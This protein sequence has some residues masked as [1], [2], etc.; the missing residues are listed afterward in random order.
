MCIHTRLIHNQQNTMPKARSMVRS[1]SFSSVELNV[2]LDQMKSYQAAAAKVAPMKKTYNNNNQPQPPAVAA[3]SSP[4][5]S[6][7]SPPSR[8]SSPLSSSTES[9]KT[10]QQQLL[11]QRADR[12]RAHGVQVCVQTRRAASLSSLYLFLCVRGLFL[13]S[14]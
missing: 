2:V 10:Q 6:A 11:G 4:S 14:F 12:S 1:K 8:P 13:V 7:T 3:R 9:K 5:P